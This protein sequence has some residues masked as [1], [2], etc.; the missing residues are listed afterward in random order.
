MKK[1]ELRWRLIKDGDAVEKS[2]WPFL[3]DSFPN[4]EVFWSLFI[5]PLTGRIDD[6]QHI[7]LRN[8]MDP[9]LEYVSMTHYTVFRSL[10]FILDEK[11]QPNNESLRN[12]YFHFGLIIEMVNVLAWE[13]YSLK[14]HVGL[15]TQK[16]TV[17]SSKEEIF[18]KFQ[19]FMENDY[20]KQIRDFIKKGR[21]VIF[22]LHSQKDCFDLLIEDA[23]FLKE[24]KSFFKQISNYRN[25]FVHTP[26]PGS[27][28]VLDQFGKQIKFA[29]KKDAIRNYKL[30]TDISHCFPDKIDDF[31]VEEQLIEMDFYKI[32]ELLNK[33]WKHF[34]DG[35]HSVV[36]T[37]KYQEIAKL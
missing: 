25:A 37:K 29:I 9:M 16:N 14:C 24:S 15:V 4:Y 35:M 22:Y 23:I 19:Q 3:K 6:P 31:I 8:S 11:K 18:K 34:I 17:I 30:W 26:L 28:F 10:C 12:V 5:V 33:I 1:E 13:L 2:Y 7:Q 27:L 32:Q 21:S 20:D 36:K